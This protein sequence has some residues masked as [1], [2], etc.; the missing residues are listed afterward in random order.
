MKVLKPVVF[1]E[2]ASIVVAAEPFAMK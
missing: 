2:F 1:A